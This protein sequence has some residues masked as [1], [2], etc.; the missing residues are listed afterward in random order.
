MRHKSLIQSL[1]GAALTLRR[2]S[3]HWTVSRT[4]IL[5]G[6]GRAHLAFK[7]TINPKNC[8]VGRGFTC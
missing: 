1:A 2:L 5:L 8:G 7:S 6:V 4:G 3:A